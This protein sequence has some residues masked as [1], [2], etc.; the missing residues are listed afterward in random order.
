MKN[1]N[2]NTGIFDR[3]LVV[4]QF[5][6]PRYIFVNKIKPYIYERIYKNSTKI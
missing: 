5:I 2:S 6:E 3:F 1:E 4:L